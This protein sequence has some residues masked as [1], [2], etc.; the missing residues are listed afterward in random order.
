MKPGEEYRRHAR[1]CRRLA[2]SAI[3]AKEREQLLELANTWEALALER[4]NFVR[5]HPELHAQMMAEE[6]SRQ[7]TEP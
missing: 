4:D 6:K 5:T 3:V 2:R 1:E 7:A